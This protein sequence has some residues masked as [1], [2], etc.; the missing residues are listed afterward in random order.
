[1]RASVSAVIAFA[2]L[3]LTYAQSSGPAP[4]ASADEKVIRLEAF[5]VSS[6]KDYGY[7]STMSA[8]A[9]G[10][11]M[12][13]KDTPLAISI[14]NEEFLFDKNLTDL[15]EALRYVPGLIAS[16]NKEERDIYSRGFTPISKA[17]GAE[18]G[19]AVLNSS[20]IS[21]VEVVK[22]PVSVLQGIAS[23]G[24]VINMVTRRPSWDS[25]YTLELGAGDYG[26]RKGF[27]SATG[28]IWRDK[29]A[30]LAEAVHIDA[31]SGWADYTEKRD[32][33]YHLALEVRPFERVS[34]LA[35]FQRSEREEVPYQHLTF[36]HPDFVAAELEAQRLYDANGLA[37][38]AAAVQ[39]GEQSAVWL[40]RKGYPSNTPGELINVN[41][42]IY[43][44][45]YRANL[46]GP[47]ARRDVSSKR[48]FLEG[49]ARITD[50]IDF[51]AYYTESETHKYG[52]LLPAF[53]PGGGWTIPFGAQEQRVFDDAS[54]F[55]AQVVGKFEFLGMK[56][57][58]LAGYE[59]AEQSSGTRTVSGAV[60]LA[61]T[62]TGPVRSILSEIRALHPNGP[63]AP[64]VR[65]GDVE[66]IYAL[67]QVS[68]FDG[69][70]IALVGARYSKS[71]QDNLSSSKTTPQVGAVYAVT[72]WLSA[73]AGYGESF[74]PNFT[75][76]GNGNIVDPT[77]ETN[78]EYGLKF[79]T[80]DGK[81]SGTVSVYDIEQKNVALRDFA[82]EAATGISPLYNVA[83]KAAS[84]GAELEFIY[85]PV[86]NYQ[87]VVSFARNWQAETLVAQDVRQQGI[88]LQG[89]TDKQ[90]SFWNKYTFTTGRLKGAYV[91]AGTQFAGKVRLH[92]S[93][94]SP[95]D[96]PEVWLFDATVGYQFKVR[97]VTT[98][99]IL[100]V[101]NL[102]DKF[103]YDQTF[104]PGMPRTFQV[105]TRFRF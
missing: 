105:L 91:G 79:E 97:D 41:E 19:G 87:M 74:R 25:R 71:K 50:A 36:A 2:S 23:A 83:G 26:Y 12:A 63:A 28:P 30:Y 1:M 51:R 37:R 27:V 80:A 32:Q 60:N 70:L 7:R 72:H 93:W 39:I 52:V 31:A 95:L 78:F 55:N 68:A 43:G 57:R 13:I 82:A 88:R 73:F 86:R 18:V 62:L 3:P 14:V 22:G 84:A 85:S 81:L 100:R 58:V 61:N 69:K 75:V 6:E 9:S 49:Q 11:G 21:R 38:P 53:R 34:L 48:L 45:G 33:N 59:Q 96:S 15:R 101:N 56:H 98:D 94:A 65:G 89:S 104:R 54:S 66:S 67:E 76:D 77:E 24:G 42:I 10:S 8:T 92:P 64:V 29:V 44:R 4:A 102:T 99:L 20:F 40:A 90:F 17:D 35:D 5:S 46:Q 47:D 103:H 16:T